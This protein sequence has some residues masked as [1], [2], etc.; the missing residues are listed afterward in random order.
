MTGQGIA[1][2][3]GFITV[4]SL[5]LAAGA[6]LTHSRWTREYRET[7]EQAARA[8]DQQIAS[9]EQQLGFVRELE[10]VRF[11]ERYIA[12]KKG[13]EERVSALRTQAADARAG[14][15]NAHKQIEDLTLDAETRAREVERLRSDLIRANQ[16]AQRLE[17]IV[18]AVHTVGPISIDEIRTELSKRRRLAAHIKGRLEM[19]GMAGEAKAAEVERLRSVIEEKKR[20]AERLARETEITRAAGAIVDAMLGIDADAREKLARHIGD[21]LEDSVRRLTDLRGR[22]PIADFLDAIERGRKRD[23]RLLGTGEAT[24]TAPGART[25]R[26]AD[27][28]TAPHSAEGAGVPN[29]ERG[30]GEAA[31]AV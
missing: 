10:S 7:A 20:V 19:L 8:K 2:I 13:L 30:A 17:Q 26:P 29:R 25:P 5:V 31:R 12:T 21:Q 27:R 6:W 23:G 24:A 4:L 15:E 28:S 11:T 14:R 22:D 18:Q 1:L 16:E 9:L 3:L